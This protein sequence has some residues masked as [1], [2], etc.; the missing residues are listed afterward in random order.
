MN[1][2]CSKVVCLGTFDESSQVKIICN[3]DYKIE[4]APRFQ[5]WFTEDP[6]EEETA[7]MDRLEAVSKGEEEDLIGDAAAAAG[8][9]SDLGKLMKTGEGIV[10][11]TSGKKGAM[12]ASA[13]QLVEL[14]EA[15][16]S[17]D[18]PGDLLMKVGKDLLNN[19]D[20]T[21]PELLQMFAKEFGWK[22]AKEAKAKGKEAALK[23]NCACPANAAIVLVFDEMA[24]LY[25]KDG[26]K[27]AGATYK[28]VVKALKDLD[29]EVTEDN[30]K[31]LGKAGK[32]KVAGLGKGSAD[33]MYEYLTTE[34][35]AKLEELRENNA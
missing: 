10:L 29:F 34:T 28:K 16:D 8:D 2:D 25:F 20:K 13:K 14:L 30:A 35:I 18:L 12:K 6:T 17:L 32:N 5:P 21:T 3:V 11:D 9:D 27:N 1:D 26:N 22:T 31:S 7:E 33:K 15:N 23:N 24:D 19:K 4:D